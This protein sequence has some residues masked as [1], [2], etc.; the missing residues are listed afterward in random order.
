MFYCIKKFYGLHE[1][2]PFPNLP[3]VPPPIYVY[4]KVNLIPN[5]FMAFLENISEDDLTMKQFL[6]LT[7]Q[8][9]FDCL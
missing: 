2:H 4:V 1:V 8:Y 7:K 9:L 6:K 3:Q 5:D